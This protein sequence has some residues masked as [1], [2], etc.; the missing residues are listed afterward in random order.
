MSTL[1]LL[2]FVVM[3]LLTAWFAFLA[4]IEDDDPTKQTG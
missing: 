3:A 4:A 2:V 1:A